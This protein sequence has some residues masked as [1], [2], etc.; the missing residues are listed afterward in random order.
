MRVSNPKKEIN[1]LTRT[2]S[3]SKW[4]E[5]LV[6]KNKFGIIVIIAIIK[7]YPIIIEYE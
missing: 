7:T 1:I 2:M 5:G 4:P 6:L 3:N